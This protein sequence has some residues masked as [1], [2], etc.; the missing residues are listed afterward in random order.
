MS[1]FPF[2]PPKAGLYITAD[3][4]CVVPLRRHLGRLSYGDYVEQPLPSGSITPSSVE[5]NIH[6]PEQLTEILMDVVGNK[7]KP[8]S[9]ALC[10]PDLCARTTILELATLPPK[11]Q[12][13]QALIQWRLQE[14]LNLSKGK[15]RISY[16][17][18]S[19]P[20]NGFAGSSDTN[21]SIRLLASAIQENII[22]AYETI[23]L[24]AR[25]VPVSIHL[26]SMA[27]F[28]MCRSLMDSILKT[29]ADTYSYEPGSQFFL[30]L[31]DWGY[32][33]IGVRDDAPVFLRTKPLRQ[34]SPGVGADPSSVRKEG[35]PSEVKEPEDIFTTNSLES[36]T[37]PLQ[38]ATLVTNELVGTLQYFFET[39][40]IPGSSDTVYPLFLIGSQDPESILPHIADLIE[41]EF[42]LDTEHGKPRFKSFP[43]F[44]SNPSL[45]VKPLSG[46]STWRGNALPAFAA[47]SDPS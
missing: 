3:R 28:N 35:V 40:A 45:N 4:F 19:S 30:Y 1:L 20:V 26:A 24:N 13:R 33:I 6:D 17:I 14:K 27:V 7:K 9:V 34:L 11:T 44:P 32:S 38:I 5:P 8:Q 22:E 46:L 16:Q 47:T 18:L 31:G 29:T 15:S 2:T 21:P 39:H 42:P 41:E 23:C 25:L 12:E 10:L 36:Q 43:L 37:S